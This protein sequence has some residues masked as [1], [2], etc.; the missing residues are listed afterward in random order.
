MECEDLPI[1]DDFEDAEYRELDIDCCWSC[2][3]SWLN[4]D[5]NFECD[6][7]LERISP[8]GICKYFKKK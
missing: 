4:T 1:V 8:T 5:G 6:F 2:Y 3:Y 7:Y